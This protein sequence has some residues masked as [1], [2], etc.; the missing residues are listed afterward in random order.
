MGN[1]DSEELELSE[2]N[3]SNANIVSEPNGPTVTPKKKNKIV[4][5]IAVVLAV[6]M[7]TGLVAGLIYLIHENNLDPQVKEIRSFLAKEGTKDYFSELAGT[8]EGT[9]YVYSIR[10]GRSHPYNKNNRQFEVSGSRKFPTK[11]FVGVVCFD[12]GHFEETAE[13]YGEIHID[14]AV[15]YI[16]FIGVKPEPKCPNLY[17]AESY[18]IL[19]YS[20]DWDQDT[21]VEDYIFDVWL[22]VEF[23]VTS[24]QQVIHYWDN[25]LNLW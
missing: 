17:S 25:S 4:I 23:G 14:G 6:L 1:N 13:Y 3:G 15:C 19:G 24:A 22:M 5:P 16:E 12:Y 8:Y 9:S 7:I 20:K 11:E 2:N 18:N 10:Y 21:D